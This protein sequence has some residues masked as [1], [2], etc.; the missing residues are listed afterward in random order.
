MKGGGGDS[1]G[2]PFPPLFPPSLPAPSFNILILVIASSSLSLLP[3]PYDLLCL[4]SV[5][6]LQFSPRSSTFQPPSLLRHRFCVFLATCYF[7]FPCFLFNS[8]LVR[9]LS[10]HTAHPLLA[11][12]Q[13][14]LL[15]ICGIQNSF[16]VVSLYTLTSTCAAD[17]FR[18]I[19]Y[20]GGLVRAR[21]TRTHKTRPP[22]RA[23]RQIKQHNPRYGCGLT[24]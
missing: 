4:S 20:A 22:K 2:H 17:R 16:D 6:Y 12:P 23:D 5:F 13:S 8:L 24:R 18:R 21:H 19:T 11:V 7:Y 14:S 1:G 9:P 3:S 15:R 10:S